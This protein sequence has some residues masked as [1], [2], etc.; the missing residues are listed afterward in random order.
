MR[1][2]VLITLLFSFNSLAKDFGGGFIHKDRKLVLDCLDAECKDTEFVVKNTK[3]RNIETLNSYLTFYRDGNDTG[4]QKRWGI[5]NI[6]IQN[7]AL[8]LPKF[9]YWYYIFNMQR[10]TLKYRKGLKPL[11]TAG[12]QKFI[13][14]SKQ[15]FDHLVKA[16]KEFQTK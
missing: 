2:L 12:N 5:Y 9:P 16:I 3:T 6:I 14:L 11:D 8:S 7:A 13:K 10:A 15:H 4:F 1:L